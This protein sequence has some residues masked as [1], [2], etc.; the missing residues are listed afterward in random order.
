MFPIGVILKLRSQGLREVNTVQIGVGWGWT[1][2]ADRGKGRWD[3]YKLKEEII[4]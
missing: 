4:V 3:V 2:V 1:S